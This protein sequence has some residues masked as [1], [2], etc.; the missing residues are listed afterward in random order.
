[1]KLDTLIGSVI[2]PMAK[3]VSHPS[4]VDPKVVC[5][6]ADRIGVKPNTR[7]KIKLLTSRHVR[8]ADCWYHDDKRHYEIRI[9]PYTQNWKRAVAHELTHI[10]QAQR[11]H[12]WQKFLRRYKNYSYPSIRAAGYED[13]PYEIE[14]K[15]NADKL[16][17]KKNIR[18]ESTEGHRG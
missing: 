2:N 6:L 10:L 7:I 12:G 8:E 3:I 9:H 16:R 1:M 17:S 4:T 18:L 13:N 14:A 5:K 11:A 15:K